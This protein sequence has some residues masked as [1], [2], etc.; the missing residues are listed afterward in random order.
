MVT[1]SRESKVVRNSAILAAQHIVINLIAIVVVGYIAR[2]LGKQDYGVY[3]LAFGFPAIFEFIG[4]LGLR[5]LI[6]REIARNKDK[7]LEFLGKVIPAQAVLIVLM[8]IFIL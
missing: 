1:V 7:S 8:T 6:I 2:K 4:S 3:A 5:P